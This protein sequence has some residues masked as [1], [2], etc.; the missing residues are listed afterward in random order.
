MVNQNKIFSFKIKCQ[1]KNVL[2]SDVERTV[3][4]TQQIAASD[5]GVNC[6]PLIQPCLDTSTGSKMDLFKFLDQNGKELTHWRLETPKQVSN[7]C[8]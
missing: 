6:F 2:L 5:Q 1:A 8:K 3:D 4:Q 7:V